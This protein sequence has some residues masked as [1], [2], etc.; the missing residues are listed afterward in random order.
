V[1]RAS[2]ALDRSLSGEELRGGLSAGHPVGDQPRDVDLAGPPGGPV[3]SD[4]LQPRQQGHQ[5]ENDHDARELDPEAQPNAPV[6]GAHRTSIVDNTFQD[7][8][9]HHE[10]SPKIGSTLDAV[11]AA[12]MDIPEL[13]ATQ[14]VQTTVAGHEATFLELT[15]PATLSCQPEPLVDGSSAPLSAARHEDI[16]RCRQTFQHLVAPKTGH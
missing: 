8:C 13:T 10:R 4:A 2:V 12:L 5:A 15:V 1:T 3:R 11:T 9:K 16:A 14:P 6:P 7:P